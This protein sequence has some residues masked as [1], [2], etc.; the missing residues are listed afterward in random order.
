MRTHYPRG[1]QTRAARERQRRTGDLL[2][3][4]DV[5]FQTVAGSR[6]YGLHRP[7]SDYDAYTVV[8]EARDPG[9]T[10]RARK[11]FH[12]MVTLPNGVVHDSYMSG[13][14]TFLNACNEGVP[15]ALEA[16]FAPPTEVDAFAAYRASFVV[17]PHRMRDTYRRSVRDH[18][19]RG[20]G[21][22]TNRTVLGEHGM[23]KCRMHAVR[24]ALN[25][26]TA[27]ETG[28][29][30]PVLTAVEKQT[31]LTVADSPTFVSDLRELTGGMV[32]LST[33]RVV[34]AAHDIN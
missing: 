11:V 26:A 9:E 23:R 31:V 12:E 24:L 21:F 25:L 34:L 29:F 30:N 6:L 10:S 27:M 14:S 18:G 5:L 19:V 16:M 33:D 7:E 28:R 13:L 1:M 17:N 20:L 8:G 22:D 3:S 4:Q 32:D 15:G 2:R